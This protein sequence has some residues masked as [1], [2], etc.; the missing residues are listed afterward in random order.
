MT[1]LKNPANPLGVDNSIKFLKIRNVK[2]PSRTNKYDAGI[3]FYVPE[4]DKDFITELKKNNPHLFQTP[5]E[6]VQVTGNFTLTGGCCSQTTQQVNYNLEDINDTPFKLDEEK[7]LY[8]LLPPHSRVRVPSGIKVKMAVPGRALIAANRS[9]IASADG[10]IYAAQVVDYPYQ[11]EVNLSVINTSTK[12]MRI[13]E[14]MKLLQ[15]LE[16]PVFESDIDVT[17]SSGFPDTDAVKFYAGETT[18]RGD[19][20]FGSSNKT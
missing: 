6:Y 7:G 2:S 12:V 16:M 10:I 14:N 18:T 17:E 1:E 3:D 4:F 19:K 11:G 15:F 13:Y 9:G 5:K 8:F 20:G